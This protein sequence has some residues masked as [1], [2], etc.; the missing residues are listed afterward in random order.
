MTSIVDK[1]KL[2]PAAVLP[3]QLDII[4]ELEKLKESENQ[5]ANESTE[6]LQ[7]RYDSGGQADQCTENSSI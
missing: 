3:G 5:D 7:Y 2:P 1:I 6:Q 4:T